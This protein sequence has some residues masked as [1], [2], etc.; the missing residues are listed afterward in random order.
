MKSPV[1]VLHYEFYDDLELVH[2]LVADYQEK[3]QC[4]TGRGFIPFGKAQYPTLDDYA[5]GVDVM[6]FLQSL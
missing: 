4:V 6:A 3:I 5:D 1:S 2:R